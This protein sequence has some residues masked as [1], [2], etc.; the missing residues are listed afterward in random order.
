V[1]WSAASAL[2]GERYRVVGRRPY[3]AM[4]PA[5]GRAAWAASA[6]TAE[7]AGSQAARDFPDPVPVAMTVCRPAQA[8]SAAVTWCSQG[9]STPRRR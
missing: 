4:L 9:R 5:S 6:R 1:S 8:A 3:A 7:I 2:V